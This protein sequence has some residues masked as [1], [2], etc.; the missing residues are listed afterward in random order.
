[1][2][3]TYSQQLEE[4]Q[5]AIAAI[6]SGAQSYSVANRSLTRADLRTL[7]EREQK[8]R[9]LAARE[10]IGGLFIQYVVAE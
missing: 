7:Y 10:K 5:A 4:V 8:L 3:K 2:L 6:E 1:M 9:A